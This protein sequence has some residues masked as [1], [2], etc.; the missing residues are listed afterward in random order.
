[1]QGNAKLPKYVA[2]FKQSEELQSNQPNLDEINIELNLNEMGI[3]I[4]DAKFDEM[5]YTV[6]SRNTVTGRYC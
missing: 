4:C 6:K 2:A 5:N 3:E 1:M